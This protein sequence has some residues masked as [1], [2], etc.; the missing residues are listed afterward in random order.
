M[1]G[2]M[3][4]KRKKELPPLEVI[5]E[6]FGERLARFRK[7]KGITQ[8]DLAEQVGIRQTLVSRY[9]CGQL[10]MSAELAVRFALALKTSCDELL[11]L[12]KNNHNGD[13]PARRIMKR[14]REIEKLPSHH[15]TTLL[16][17]IDGFLRGV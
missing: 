3:P 15:Q 11:G 2:Y 6:P 9:E 7:E 12:E 14:V 17:M 13:K 10:Q 8:V 1:M 5:S 4:Q 16:R